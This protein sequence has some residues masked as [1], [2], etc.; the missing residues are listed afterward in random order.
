MGTKRSYHDRCAV[1]HALELVGERWALLVVRELFLGPKRFTDLRHGLP[2]ISPNVLTQ[3]LTELEASAI[4][5]RRKLP[6][7]ASAWI[8]ELTPWGAELEPMILGLGHWAA[9]SPSR[10]HDGHFGVD[11]AMLSLR[12]VFSPEAARG[13]TVTVAFHFGEHHFSA[14]V[15]NGVLTLERGEADRPEAVL[16]TDP[17][18]YAAVAYMGRPLEDAIASGAL[19]FEGDP[20]AFRRLVSCIVRPVPVKVAAG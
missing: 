20:E 8:Y 1:A 14:H 15:E 18:T 16:D 9:R 10:T 12:T 2:G 11:S 6:P 5:H 3:R 13:V 7:P 19:R 4:V 17:D